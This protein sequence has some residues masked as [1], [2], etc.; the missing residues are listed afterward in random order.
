MM[1]ISLC[2]CERDTNTHIISQSGH[3][4]KFVFEDFQ[5][6]TGKDGLYLF[7]DAVFCSDTDT[8]MRCQQRCEKTRSFTAEE[9]ESGG[10]DEETVV[11]QIIHS[12]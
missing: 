11:K 2:R 9:L 8:S 4:L 10:Y 6:T 1:I 3:E 7:C 12:Y 5:Y